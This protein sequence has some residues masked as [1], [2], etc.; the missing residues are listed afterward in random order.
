MGYVDTSGDVYKFRSPQHPGKPPLQQPLT[1]PGQRNSRLGHSLHSSS[2]HVR[3]RNSRKRLR[4][5]ISSVQS[6]DTDGSSSTVGSNRNTPRETSIDEPKPTNV[7]SDIPPPSRT[8]KRN[9]S[10][11]HSSAE[12]HPK[13]SKTSQ[14]AYKHEESEDELHTSKVND[15]RSPPPRKRT[16][17][18]NG[19]P[20]AASLRNRHLHPKKPSSP[21]SPRN[22][23][24]KN[25]TLELAEAAGDSYL[26]RS[27]GDAHI[28]LQESRSDSGIWEPWTHAGKRMQTEWLNIHVPSVR[29]ILASATHSPIIILYRPGGVGTSSQLALRFASREDAA[30]FLSVFDESKQRVCEREP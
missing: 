5:S 23:T 16:S 10:S 22:A 26:I 25:R 12:P 7:V 8:A 6:M 21:V 19:P 17:L 24:S 1:S 18:F 20:T 30:L 29:K 4:D 15:V 28:I 2:R 14:A 27:K 13:R 3:E 11:L 9:P